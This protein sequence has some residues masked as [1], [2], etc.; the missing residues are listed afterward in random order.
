M[1]E[2]P[3]RIIVAPSQSIHPCEDVFDDEIASTLAPSAGAGTWW[4]RGHL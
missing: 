1:A 2:N 4:R 3:N